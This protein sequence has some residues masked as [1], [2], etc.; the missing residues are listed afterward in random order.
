M[1][2]FYIHF[3]TPKKSGLPNIGG[4]N[5]TPITKMYR[6]EK[7]NPNKELFFISDFKSTKYQSENISDLE[8]V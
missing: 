4:P 3:K 1:I 8:Q 5:K 6:Y 2:K 7:N